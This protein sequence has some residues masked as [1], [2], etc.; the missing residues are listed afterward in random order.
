MTNDVTMVTINE[1]L[2]FAG[3]GNRKRKIPVLCLNTTVDERLKETNLTFPIDD[4]LM[5][6]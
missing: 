3:I 1:N 5:M 6:N 2:S 4:E